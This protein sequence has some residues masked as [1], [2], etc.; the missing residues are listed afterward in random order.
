MNHDYASELAAFAAALANREPWPVTAWRLSVSIGGVDVTA[1]V[2]TDTPLTVRHGR[3]HTNEQPDPNTAVFTMDNL[4]RAPTV[5]M[6]VVVELAPPGMPAV[7]WFTGRVSDVTAKLAAG[8]TQMEVV[9][10]STGLGAAARR[11]IGDEPWPTETDGERIARILALCPDITVGTVDAG[12]VAVLNRD[13]DHREALALLAEYA[14]TAMGMLVDGRDGSV[15][16]HDAAHRSVDTPDMVISAG[17]LRTLPDMAQ[18][19]G[20]VINRVRVRY[21]TEETEIKLSDEDSIAEHGLFE[22]STTTQLADASAARSIGQRVLDQYAQ[23]LYG[24]ELLTIPLH[25]LTTARAAELAVLGPGAFIEVTGMP[26][27]AP[28]PWRCWIEGVRDDWRGLEWDREIY[29]SDRWSAPQTPPPTG[30]APVDCAVFDWVNECSTTNLFPTN[31]PATIEDG[32]Y[33][34]PPEFYEWETN[35]AWTLVVP[36]GAV[37]SGIFAGIGLFGAAR[38]G[39][40]GPHPDPWTTGS[41]PQDFCIGLD[42]V[43]TVWVGH[44]DGPT[45]EYATISGTEWSGGTLVPA[46][47]LFSWVPDAGWPENAAHWA[48]GAGPPLDPETIAPGC[49][50]VRYSEYDYL[51]PGL[52]RQPTAVGAWRNSPI[53]VVAPFGESPAVP[54]LARVR[55][56]YDLRVTRRQ[57]WSR[58]SF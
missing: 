32:P 57:R 18:R 33:F 3:A 34:T 2:R 58:A 47:L 52:V 22:I 16:Y 31:A 12:T 25:T 35:G 44:I 13:I 51:E 20:Q 5:G 15:S 41:D 30:P 43:Q 8:A 19:V 29:V 27:P 24:S 17:E 48:D 37:V 39:E 42:T 53:F 49:R 40:S 23:P 45:V 14:S 38:L 9:A 54:S 7:P 6:P 56:L 55:T 36:A 4:P 10:V 21:G 50:K 46:N 26:A 1:V 11:F 28:D